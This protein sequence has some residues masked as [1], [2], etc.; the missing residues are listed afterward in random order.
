MS[1][2]QAN[3][4]SFLK[5]I[6][7]NLT[8]NGLPEKKVSLPLEKLYEAADNRDVNLNKV[9]ERLE[10]E[11]N[12]SHSKNLDKIIFS[13]NSSA[14]NFFGDSSKEDMMKQAAE[15]MKNMDPAQLEEIR[16]LYENMSPQEKE[17]IMR[18]A[19]DMGFA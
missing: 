17:D 16:R 3:E 2:H 12:I 4:D 10:N 5:L 11:E 6:M 18:K 7:N 1:D 13:K 15:M 19:K 8:S 9:L 14:P